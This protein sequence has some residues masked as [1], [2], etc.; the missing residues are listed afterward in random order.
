MKKAHYRAR[1]VSKDDFRL[2]VVIAAAVVAAI[3]M[4]SSYK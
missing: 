2:I 4:S 3:C 1:K